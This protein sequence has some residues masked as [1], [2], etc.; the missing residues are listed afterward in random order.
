MGIG[1]RMLAGL[2]ALVM[3]CCICVVPVS[4]AALPMSEPDIERANRYENTGQPEVA[5]VSANPAL[6]ETGSTETVTWPFENA[7]VR[8]LE[9]GELLATFLTDP[10]ATSNSTWMLSGQWDETDTWGDGRLRYLS[11]LT[12]GEE[13]VNL[14]WSAREDMKEATSV[15]FGLR[16]D[17]LGVDSHH[18]TNIERVAVTVNVVCDGREMTG[19]VFVAPGQWVVVDS[20]LPLTSART[21]ADSI[22]VQIAYDGGPATV[23]ITNPSRSDK[24]C[25][26]TAEFSASAIEAGLGDVSVSSHWLYLEPD[27]GGAVNL[28]GD[29]ELPQYIPHATGW[30]MAVT[31][32]GTA[33]GGTI[34]VGT[35]KNGDGVETWR[36][37]ASLQVTAGSHTYLFPLPAQNRTDRNT[38]EKL[39]AG[40]YTAPYTEPPDRYRVSF[41]NVTGENGPSFRISHIA[42]WPVEEPQWQESTLGSLGMGQVQDGEMVWRGKLTR[43]AA[44]TYREEEIALLALPIWNRYNLNGARELDRVQVSN[45]YTF[46][47]PVQGREQYGAGWLFYAAIRVTTKAQDPSAGEIVTYLPISQPKM[48]AGTAIEPC[49]LSLFGFHDAGAVGVYEANVSHVTVDVIWDRLLTGGEQGVQAGFGGSTVN[50][51]QSYLTELDRDIQFYCDAGLEVG[52]RLAVE[53]GGTLP[54][55]D[56]P[57]EAGQYMAVIWYLCRRYPAI[58]SITL[59][60]GINCEQY[61]SGSLEHPERVYPHVAT[62]AALTYQTARM[63]IPDVF[64]VIPFADS[65]GYAVETAAGGVSLDAETALILFASAMEEF[66][67]IHWAASWRLEDDRQAEEAAT[68]PNRWKQVLQSL[69]LPTFGD[70]LYRWEPDTCLRGEAEPYDL[71]ERYEALCRSLTTTRPRAVILSLT[72]VAEAVS[73]RMYG[74]ITGLKDPTGTES[75]IRQVQKLTGTLMEANKAPATGSAMTAVWDFAQSYDRQGFVAG[76]GISRLYTYRLPTADENGVYNRVLRSELP[77]YLFENMRIGRSGGVLLRNFAGNVDLSRVDYLTFTYTLTE[78]GPGQTESSVVFLVGSEDFRAEYKVEGTVSG[79]TVTA[80]CDLR[81]YDHAPT[82]GYVGVMVY[83]DRELSFDLASVRA[84]SSRLTATELEAVFTPP[85]PALP[86]PY[87]GEVLTMIILVAISSVC[88]TVLLARRDREEEQREKEERKSY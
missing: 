13:P 57:A 87:E 49:D 41:Q 18:K 76:G 42:L 4:A 17:P 81:Q 69:S 45:S 85:E 60:H 46:T 23:Q 66:G 72:H 62:L 7:C 15:A 75:A 35:H 1:K 68:L 3:F 38:G 20:A 53:K 58:A 19:K 65:Q 88:I 6:P 67:N 28:I 32:E 48:L 59:G 79:Q 37:S 43:Q 36:E 50:L 40:Y 16:V 74:R 47:L 27:S 52:L 54:H 84:W 11:L 44:T 61:S 77:M 73:Q 5:W 51:S 21:Y 63:V 29:T 34:S 33:A 39:T 78:K 25:A 30:Y 71:T 12:G 2:C 80:V 24:D 86:S 10:I 9:E 55:A 56:T 14:R 82:T 31:V 83:G 8:I 70:F 64:I 26:F 22:Q